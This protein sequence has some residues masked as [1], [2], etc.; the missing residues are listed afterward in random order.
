MS[1]ST[2]RY[3]GTSWKMTKTIDEART[4]AA[5]LVEAVPTIPA[6]VQPFILP[7]HTALATVHSVL[8]D[9]S[10]VILGAQNAHWAAP[11]A[12]TGEV[13]MEQVRDAGATLVEIGHSERRAQFGETDETVM[14]KTRRAVDLGLR[15][16]V[17][18]GESAATRSLGGAVDY[19]MGQVSQ[20][21]ASLQ[22][23]ELGRV[24]VAYEP[25]WAI[26][27]NGTASSPDKVADVLAEV[28][29]QWQGLEAVLYGGSVTTS[30][31]PGYFELPY[32][33]GLFIG[34][35]A[36]SVEGYLSFLQLPGPSAPVAHGRPSATE[37][38]EV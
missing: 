22:S 14:L 1:P 6:D 18:V 30:N 20:A 17:C 37:A 32:L 16:L 4:F 10:P 12:H 23:D 2:T 29:A 21:L 34:R 33:D 28:R 15:A 7:S 36:W 38:S 25:Q 8:G 24:I 3:I 26:G 19:V 5:R 13:S 9:D 35:A 27:E 31:A 11:G